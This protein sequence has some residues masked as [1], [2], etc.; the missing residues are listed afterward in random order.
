MSSFGAEVSREE[1]WPVAEAGH[2]VVIFWMSLLPGI[3]QI[4]VRVS[5]EPGNTR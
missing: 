4:L 5:D 2:W 3:A 1:I